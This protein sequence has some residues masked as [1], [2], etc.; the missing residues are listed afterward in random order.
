MNCDW[1]EERLPQYLEGDVSLDERR[2]VEDHLESCVR[3][4]ESLDAFAELEKSLGR[5]KTAVPSWKT[6]EGRFVRSAGFD[7]RRSFAAFVFNVPFLTGLTFITFGI[8]CF[9]KGYAMLTALQFLGDRSAVSLEGFGQTL[10]RWFEAF[11]G[12]NPIILISI[13]GLLLISFLGA[14]RLIVLRF[15][16]Q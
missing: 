16:K 7:R 8:A 11:A 15:G 9:L 10:A 14:S 6:A 12:V 3:C 5:L 2:I 1:I 4:R 13:Y